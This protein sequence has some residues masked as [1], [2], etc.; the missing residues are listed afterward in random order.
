MKHELIS[1]SIGTALGIIGSATQDD[2]II[3]LISIIFTIIGA[4][5]TY[6]I[7]PLIAW[8]K[9]SKKDGK[10]DVNEIK[11]GIDII[12]DGSQ[13]IKDQVDEVKQLDQNDEIKKK[14]DK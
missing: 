6:I 14:E 2:D 9:K 13:N 5:I 11:E 12:S 3:R 7:V 8:Y 10:I 1:G 4:V